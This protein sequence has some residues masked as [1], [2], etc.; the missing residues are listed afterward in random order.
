VNDQA[1]SLNAELIELAMEASG[2]A[3][4]ICGGDL[5]ITYVNRACLGLWGYERAEQVL[6][7]P[8]SEFWG[9]H[10]AAENAAREIAWGGCWAGE[11]VARRVDGTEFTARVT[12]NLFS[13]G[14]GGKPRLVATFTDITDR[15]RLEEQLRHS[16]KMEAVGLLAGGIAHDFNNLLTVILGGAAF[17][18]DA[19]GPGDPRKADADQILTAARR[20]EALTRQLLAFS[21]RQV[22]HPG[23]LDLNRAVQ[24]VSKMV[25]RLIGEQID[26][27]LRLA[28]TPPIVLADPAL[29]EQALMNLMVNARDAM[30]QGGRLEVATA[31]RDVAGAEAARLEVPSGRYAVLSVTDD[32]VGI[33]DAT[34]AR[35]F[36]PYF[37]TKEH[38]RGTGLGLSTVYGIARQA[39]GAVEVRSRPGEGST[40]SILFPAQDAASAPAPQP[41]PDAPAPAKESPVILIAEDEAAVRLVAER[42]LKL[43]G[44][45]V[46][47]APD[48]ESAL[49]L[50]SEMGQLDLLL[51]DVVMPGIS[52][53]QLADRLK[54]VHP[55]TP[56]LFMTGYTD[57]TALRL[58][59][60]TNQVRILSKPFT[61]DS[62]AA[63]VAEAIDGFAEGRAP[64][65]GRVK[66]SE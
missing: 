24:G 16:Q 4:A 54:E 47:S 21:R 46:R 33:D 25:R 13:G 41:R 50:A 53:R 29:L 15:V 5:R 43:R 57:D 39:G 30:E 59:I 11:L 28:P 8:A 48:G 31:M 2:T 22:L 45:R 9:S 61:P 35:I 52:G 65:G 55:R 42:C 38:G 19:F 63:A 14:D 64:G 37:T 56:V 1:H 44:Y 26:V 20:A 18:E 36:E 17:L 7:R 23:L 34:L 3:L 10:E 62:L 27:A 49:K 40:F 51:T 12:A 58:G 6:G 32:G 66:T 60:E